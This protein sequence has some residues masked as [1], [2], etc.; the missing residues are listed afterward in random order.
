MIAPVQ[1][2]LASG[3]VYKTE[4]IFM[5][6]VTNGYRLYGPVKVSCLENGSWSADTRMV[7]CQGKICFVLL[8]LYFVLFYVSLFVNMHF[9]YLFTYLLIYSF[10][11]YLFIY[12][13]LIAPYHGKTC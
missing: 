13:F 8:L 3:V 2:K 5:C 6:N 9:I 4:C 11:N 12:C 7:I 1:C 10:I